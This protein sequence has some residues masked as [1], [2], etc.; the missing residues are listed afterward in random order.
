MNFDSEGQLQVINL[1]VRKVNSRP[2]PTRSRRLRLGVRRV[3][4]APRPAGPTRSPTTR[5]LRLRVGPARRES[6]ARRRA[7]RAGGS[8][9]RPGWPIQ[10]GSATARVTGTSRSAHWY[11]HWRLTRSASKAG[12]LQVTSDSA[13]LGLGDSTRRAG[14][15][16]G[17]HDDRAARSG[18]EIYLGW[19]ITIR[20]LQRE[21]RRVSLSGAARSRSCR[22]D[23]AHAQQ[24]SKRCPADPA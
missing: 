18:C 10:V 9:S 15:G 13:G 16:P 24:V 6:A 12:D 3:T 8:Q 11:W 5:S 4:V 21:T 19:L 2:S 20:P 23:C 7:G 22:L 14:A 1:N 17:H